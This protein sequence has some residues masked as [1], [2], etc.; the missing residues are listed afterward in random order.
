MKRQL[1]GYI[2]YLDEDYKK[3]WENALIV[4]DANVIL[5]FYRYNDE[6]RKELW[7]ILDDSKERLW[8]PFQVGFEYC[9]NRETV[10][11]SVQESFKIVKAQIDKCEHEIENVLQQVGN[12]DIK[13]KKDIIQLIQ[14]TNQKVKEKIDKEKEE[15]SDF[16]KQDSI[17]KK[18]L[19][20][21]DGK[22]EEK[23]SE[24]VL[25]EIKKVALIRLEN[26]IPPG[27]EDYK[28]EKSYGD[29]YI[30]WSFIKKAKEDKRDVIFIT[31]DEKEDW[32]LKKNGINQ[33][34]R[35]ELLQEFYE[36]TEQLLFICTT[37]MFVKGYNKYCRGKQVPKVVIE[38]IDDV[39]KKEE[40]EAIIEPYER[41]HLKTTTMIRNKDSELLEKVVVMKHLLL[42]MTKEP[43]RKEQILRQIEDISKIIVSEIRY[44]RY[45]GKILIIIDE[46]E[47][48]DKSKEDIFYCITLLNKIIEQIRN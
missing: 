2:P 4:V 29:Y 1:Q 13:C 9:K 43:E 15:K 27:Y 12:R 21:Y 39:H 35:P 18:I 30:F 3:I 17:M 22:C 8:M 20:L 47:K 33:G 36:K 41:I 7:G 14:Q 37:K 31:D 44:E 45:H 46:L 40:L 25:E 16:E 6:T 28:K 32:Y 24:D 5:N 48:S 34:G 38:N 23:V 26:K 19:E 11:E 42:E 10:I